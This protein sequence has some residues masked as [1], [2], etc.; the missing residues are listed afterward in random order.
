MNNLVQRALSGT[1]FVI[2]LVGSIIWNQYSFG[3]LFAVISAFAIF[4]FH[5]L[6]NTQE[7]VRVNKM[8]AVVGALIIFASSFLYYAFDA[9]STNIF[10]IYALF[11]VIAFIAEL[12]RK[13]AQPIHNWAYFI[14]GQI[15]IA[16]PF[17]LLNFI[18][19]SSDYQPLILLAVFV[20]IWVNDTGAYL[21]GITF[22]KNRLFERI[23]P[24]KSWEGFVGGAVFA[25]IPAYVFSLFITEMSLLEWII[26]AEIIVIFGTFGDLI[27]SLLKRTLSVKDSGDAIPGHGGLLD[28]FDSMLIAV[29]VIFMYLQFITLIP[30]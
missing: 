23:S 29:P 25:L 1:V 9:F 11:I 4:E 7:N 5:K 19:F 12:Y 6:T 15:Y 22:G 21:T 10:L 27:E 14:L 30:K 20:T 17:A 18:L 3:I 24:K 8:F 28:R 26:F 13:Q 2:L 16:L